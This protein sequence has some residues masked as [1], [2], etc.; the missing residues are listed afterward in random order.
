M[1]LNVRNGLQGIAGFEGAD[2]KE[3]HDMSVIGN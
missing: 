2:F 3:M 1:L